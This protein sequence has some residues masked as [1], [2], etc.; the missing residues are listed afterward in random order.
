M[1][2]DNSGKRNGKDRKARESSKHLQ[3]KKEEEIGTKLPRITK[4]EQKMS[5][6]EELEKR[7]KGGHTQSPTTQPVTPVDHH[8]EKHPQKNTGGKPTKKA[9][10]QP[11]SELLS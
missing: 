7:D 4:M 11:E 2:G 9:K 5:A 6:T 1:Y 3:G 8:K 10:K